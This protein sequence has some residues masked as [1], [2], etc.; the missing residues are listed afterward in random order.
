V[1][2]VTISAA[3]TVDGKIATATGE[4]A[5]S[6]PDDLGRVHRMRAASDAVLI[7][8]A[9]ALADDPLL[10]VRLVKGRNPARVVV[11]SRGRLPKESRLLRTAKDVRT[12]VAVTEHAPAE[13]VEMMRKAGAQVLVVRGSKDSSSSAAPAVDL[14]A[15]FKMLDRMGLKKILAEGGGE[16]NWS[17]LR[18][19]LVDR[20]VVTVAP[21][22]V[23]GR[24]AT[25]L[26]EGDG[27]EAVAKGVR[28]KL[29]RA[30]RIKKTGELVLYYDVVSGSH[31]STF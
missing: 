21:R 28:L 30:Q 22:V 31:H 2:K 26:V 11:D 20:L 14:K 6:S 13:N 4:S 8:V 25:T 19:D 10:T 16:L 17:L 18:L 3:M 29:A 7:G 27:Y 1:I 9:T 24:L 23:G 15:L 12:I 5:I